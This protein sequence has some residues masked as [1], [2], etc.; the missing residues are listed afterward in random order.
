MSQ[1][2]SYSYFVIYS[3]SWR[4]NARREI[5]IVFLYF[6]TFPFA[7]LKTRTIIVSLLLLFISWTSVLFGT[8]YHDY[9][10]YFEWKKVQKT[11]KSYSRRASITDAYVG[12]RR[13]RPLL[14]AGDGAKCDTKLC[15]RQVTRGRFYRIHQLTS[16]MK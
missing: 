13:C 9:P 5:R 15:A 7:P 1:K 10:C 4:G 6:Y 16:T 12:A 11:D 2:K 3:T 8:Q 14:L